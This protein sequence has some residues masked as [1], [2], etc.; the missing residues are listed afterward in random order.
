MK[1]DYVM[2]EEMAINE[3][4]EFK[5]Q[6]DS[7]PTENTDYELNEAFKHVIYAIRTG[8]LNLSGDNPILELFKPLKGEDDEIVL[9]EIKFK[10]RITTLEMEKLSKGINVKTELFKLANLMNIN[11]A[12]INRG[13]YDKMS[14]TD[15]SVVTELG[16]LFF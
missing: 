15:T 8:K 13:Y 5:S 4:R 14:K 7:L 9:S 6:Y 10:T 16:T 12:G 3:L 2:S 1:L 11:L